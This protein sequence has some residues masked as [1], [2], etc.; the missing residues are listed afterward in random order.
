MAT[1]NAAGASAIN[2]E[3]ICPLLLRVF[4]A[5]SRHNNLGDF[6]RGNFFFVE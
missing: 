4:Y 5:S 3:K 1:A 6:N 2:R